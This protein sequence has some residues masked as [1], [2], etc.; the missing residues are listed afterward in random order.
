MRYDYRTELF[1]CNVNG[2]HLSYYAYNKYLKELA[3]RV[4]HR[5]NVTT[6]IMRHTHVSLLAEAGVPLEA[7]TRRVGHVDSDIT[8]KIYLHVTKKLKEKD[9]EQIRK[10]QIL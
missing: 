5:D 10:V 2:A 7:I 8:R 9:R 6:H 1:M 4:L 3:Q